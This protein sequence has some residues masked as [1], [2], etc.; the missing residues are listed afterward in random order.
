ML[1]EDHLYILL[2]SDLIFSFLFTGTCVIF[3]LTSE[4]HSASFRYTP[5]WQIQIMSVFLCKGTAGHIN[6][7]I[8]LSGLG[9]WAIVLLAMA[10]NNNIVTVF[11]LPFFHYS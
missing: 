2:K 3:L 11:G 9:T 4:A 7:Y 10:S 1:Q 6:G 8:L 5:R